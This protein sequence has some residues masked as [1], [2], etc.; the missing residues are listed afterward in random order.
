MEPPM[1]PS[2]NSPPPPDTNAAPGPLPAPSLRATAMQW[3]AR[4]DWIE[5]EDGTVV[6]VAPGYQPSTPPR[7]SASVTLWPSRRCLMVAAPEM[8]AALELVRDLGSLWHG[9][10][11]DADKRAAYLAVISAIS[12]ARP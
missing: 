6:A 5:A 3:I 2:T 11:E 1:L 7:L 8:L 12:Q 9:V 10:A 4:A